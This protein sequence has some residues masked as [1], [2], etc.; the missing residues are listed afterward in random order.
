MSV[1][2]TIISFLCIVKFGFFIM[3]K[4]DNFISEG[5]FVQKRKTDDY[6][7]KNNL[8]II[9][10]LGR[11]LPGPTLSFTEDEKLSIDYITDVSE[12]QDIK[13]IG[14]PLGFIYNDFEDLVISSITKKRKDDIQIGAVCNE[15]KNK[16]LFDMMNITILSP[17]KLTSEYLFSIIRF[18]RNKQEG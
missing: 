11:N 4:L 17:E 12:I 15:I 1:A 13:Q 2:L 14:I 7:K 3:D 8:I 9:V 6:P 5:G 10:Y 16:R 18:L